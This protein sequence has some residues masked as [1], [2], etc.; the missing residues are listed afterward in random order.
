MFLLVSCGNVKRLQFLQLVLQIIRAH[1]E[2]LNCLR[3]TKDLSLW[4]IVVGQRGSLI[5]L[6]ATF[7]G[8]LIVGITLWVV[9]LYATESQLF[10][11][12]TQRPGSAQDWLWT[13]EKNLTTQ[14]LIQQDV[15]TLTV[16]LQIL[17]EVV[18]G[19]LVVTSVFFLHLKCLPH[20]P[21]P[22]LLQLHLPGKQ[23]TG[24]L[25]SPSGCPRF[26]N[27]LFHV[28]SELI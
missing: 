13:S 28:Q 25:V 20:L 24:A 2:E 23:A 8:H 9:H 11:S 3:K 18:L 27:K 15:S 12:I 19:D 14:D 21:G 22:S 17:L 26:P 10:K 6:P 7:Q 5:F 4:S 1:L 16:K